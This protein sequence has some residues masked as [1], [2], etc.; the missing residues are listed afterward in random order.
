MC[1]GICVIAVYFNI[2]LETVRI[3]SENEKMVI[4]ATLSIFNLVIAALCSVF[5]SRF[6]RRTIFLSSL[7]SLLISYTIWT[8]LS[9]LTV[10]SHFK[11][12]GLC[13]GV[14]AL[15]YISYACYNVGFQGMPFVYLTEILPYALR[16]KGLLIYSLA[17]ESFLIFNGFVNPVAI[18]AIGWKYYIVFCASISASLILCYF[19][20]PE[21]GGYTLEQVAVAFGDSPDL[22]LD[23]EETTEVIDQQIVEILDDVK[24]LKE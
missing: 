14:L 15:T 18:D 1:T 3:T 13:Q 21:T 5:T 16:S 10:K 4:T 22:I 12:K 20:F 9:A 17:E 2:V 23:I 24:I 6:K 19:F 7:T 8:I 11:N